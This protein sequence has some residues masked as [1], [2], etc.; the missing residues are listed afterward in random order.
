MKIILPVIFICLFAIAA[1]AQEKQS[2]NHGFKDLTLRMPSPKAFDLNNP[3]DSLKYRKRPRFSLPERHPDPL[4]AEKRKPE[5]NM[6]VIRPPKGHFP[7][8]PVYEPDTTVHY[9]LKI[10]KF[11][12]GKRPVRPASPK[13]E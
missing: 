8:M 2:E 13:T 11:Q 10:K 1:S 4:L 5:D 6:P 3:N 9:T 7:S 12:G